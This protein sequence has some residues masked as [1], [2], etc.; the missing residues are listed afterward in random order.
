VFFLP[1]ASLFIVCF[2]C[3]ISCLFWVV[4]TTESAWTRLWNDLLCVSANTHSPSET[5][6][7][8]VT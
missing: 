4:S 2:W 5:L 6:W 7:W 1:A 3:I 8:C